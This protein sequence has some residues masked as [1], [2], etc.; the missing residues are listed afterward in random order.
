MLHSIAHVI[1]QQSPMA[2]KSAMDAINRPL[3]LLTPHYKFTEKGVIRTS[4]RG[5]YGIV[6]VRA[7]SSAAASY[8]VN[9]SRA[10]ARSARPLSGWDA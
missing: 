1:R 7:F 9:T 4:L 8:L 10:W 3:Q 5:I 6:S 2:D